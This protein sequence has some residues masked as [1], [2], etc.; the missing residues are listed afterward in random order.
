MAENKNS[1]HEIVF[2]PQP[3]LRLKLSDKIYLATALRDEDVTKYVYSLVMLGAA[4]QYTSETSV[5]VT[6]FDDAAHANAYFE[7]LNDVV[8]VYKNHP[9]VSKMQP[10]LA[11]RIK[12]FEDM[13]ITR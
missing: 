2:G 4:G 7:A 3:K 12:I 8:A 1:K 10:L 9:I 6:A 13:F 11:P 5:E